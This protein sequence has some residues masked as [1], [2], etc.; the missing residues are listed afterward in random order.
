MKKNGRNETPK[1]GLPGF[2]CKFHL[3]NCGWNEPLACAEC[4]GTPAQRIMELNHTLCSTVTL[5]DEHER[6]CLK[7]ESD[8]KHL[9]QLLANL[10]KRHEENAKFVNEVNARLSNGVAHLTRDYDPLFMKQES[11]EADLAALTKKLG[12][13]FNR[14]NNLEWKA[15]YP[16]MPTPTVAGQ[17]EDVKKEQMLVRDFDEQ[18]HR[19]TA[20]VIDD[21]HD[22]IDRAFSEYKKEVISILKGG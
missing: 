8:I 5:V 1:D 20:K 16:K 21:L 6:E 7:L 10:T 22:S 3:D 12:D 17:K 15:G 4:F 14:I 9:A 11:T 2:E 18:A 13:A 19:I